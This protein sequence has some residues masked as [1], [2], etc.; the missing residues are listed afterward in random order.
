[1]IVDPTFFDVEDGIPAKYGWSKP[2]L[3]ETVWRSEVGEDE[4]WLDT[5]EP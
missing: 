5:M 4:T 1:V 2:K 3:V